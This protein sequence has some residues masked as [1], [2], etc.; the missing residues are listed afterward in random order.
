MKRSH[1][2]IVLAIVFSLALF[3]AQSWASERIYQMTGDITAIDIEYNTVVI[4]VPMGGK[5]FTVGGPLSSRA[6]LERGGQSAA[7]ADFQVG[8]RVTVKWEAAGQ[9]HLIL[10]LSPSIHKFDDVFIYSGLSAE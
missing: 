1:F 5:T 2:I 7:L 10:S 4:E 6:V 3:G 8:D 9:G